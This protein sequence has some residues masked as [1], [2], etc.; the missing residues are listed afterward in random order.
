MLRRKT[1]SVRQRASDVSELALQLAQDKRFR[2]RLR[3]AAKHGKQAWRH[4][5]R[6]PGLRAAARRLAVDQE[7]QAE[8][9]KARSDLQLAYERLDAKRGGHRKRR[10]VALVG[11]GSLAAVPQVRERVSDLIASAARNGKDIQNLASANGQDREEP[12]PNSLDDLTKEELY[13]RAQ[14]AEI[15]GRSEMSK[16]ELVEALRSRAGS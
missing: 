15:A 6:G 11:L 8:L 14:E 4:T 2:K 10:V 9:Q 13:A 12:R 5:R 3:S 1:D 16:E 7:L